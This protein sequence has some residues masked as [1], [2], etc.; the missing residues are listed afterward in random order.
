MYG[1]YI[2]RDTF[3]DS[4]LKIDFLMVDNHIMGGELNFSLGR[5]N[6]GA[7]IPTLITNMLFF[8]QLLSANGVLDISP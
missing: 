5:P 8:T 1:P 6:F 2:E 7:Q 3:W 4:L